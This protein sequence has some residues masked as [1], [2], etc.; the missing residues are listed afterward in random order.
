VTTADRKTYAAR[1]KGA[2]PRSDLAVLEI[3][4]HDLVPVRFGDA[5]TLRKGQIVIALGNPYAISRDGQASA[6]WGMVSNLARKLH[7][8]PGD[9]DRPLGKPKL[10]H[11]GWL[12]RTDAK[13]HLGTSGGPL[14]NLRGEMIGLT[15]ALAAIAGYEQGAGFAVPVDDTFR[16]VVDALVR[17]RE[18]EYG[19]LGVSPE[20]LDAQE[21]RG[22]KHGARITAVM[23]GTPAD[24]FGLR[25]YDVVSAVNGEPIYDADGLVYRV[26]R[27]PVESVVKLTVEREGR[28][29][30]IDV[31]LAK[32]PVDGK[33]IITTPEPPWRGLNVD[34]FT[35]DKRLVGVINELASE[36]V[37]GVVVTAVEDNSPAWRAELR[38]G[39]LISH[40]GGVPVQSPKQFHAAVAGRRGAVPV[41]VSVVPGRPE[42]RI[43][44]PEAG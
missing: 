19:F 20:N 34:Y 7:G 37:I 3:D 22:G 36:G 8:E 2:D 39:M 11:V 10:Q 25:Q 16:R 17:G 27:L 30:S 38:T 4:A 21:I 31:E 1:I 35:A 44:E 15:T 41:R 32:Y 24:R 12:I 14:L 42:E 5:S 6:C 13:L 29:T 43:V 18:V 23:S 9:P 33:K 40:V 28:P 26:G